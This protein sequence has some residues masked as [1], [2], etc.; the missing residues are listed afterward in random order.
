MKWVSFLILK[1]RHKSTH[2][3]LFKPPSGGF[4]GFSPPIGVL[5]GQTNYLV[6]SELGR[7][8]E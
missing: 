2:S 4:F 6:S 7:N 3:L 1:R 5:A 8:I